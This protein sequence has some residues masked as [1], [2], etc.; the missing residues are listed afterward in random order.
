MA[1]IKAVARILSSSRMDPLELEGEVKR[2]GDGNCAEEIF[3]Q[4]GLL[5]E[6]CEIM[7]IRLWKCESES[8]SESVT[9]KVKVWKGK[10]ESK[11][12]KGKV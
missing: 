5:R 12:E 8:E 3:Q 11:S 7:K 9:V 1:L 4:E 10:C 2:A 6:K